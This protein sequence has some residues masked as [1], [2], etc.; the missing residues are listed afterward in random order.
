MV[1]VI[2]NFGGFYPSWVYFNEAR[3]WG[4]KIHLPC[5]NRG[6]YKTC[7]SGDDM[8]VGFIHIN[9]LETH[10][11]KAIHPERQ[12]GGDYLDMDDFI[13]RVQAPLE[14]LIILIR[15]G[16]FRFTGKPKA[17]LLWEAHM[18][19]GKNILLPGS[20]KA[21]KRA[22][23]Q[24]SGQRLGH[25]GGNKKQSLV[26][27]HPG[28]YVARSLQSVTDTPLLVNQSLFYAQPKKF[29]LP[30]LEQSKL[31]EVYDEIE[32]LGWPVTHSYF[33]LL[34][35]SFRGEVMATD[36]M[37]CLGR[38]VRMLGL[39]VTIKYVRTVKK[40]WMH[41]GT[42]I[43]VHGQ[44]FDTVHFPQAVNKY[45]FR[46]EGVYLI[47]GKIVEEFGFP[48]LEVEKMAKMPLQK[49]PRG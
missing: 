8:Y 11:G 25:R 9:N 6:E 26:A 24:E 28:A 5:V 12:R 43:D 45:P 49:D 16:A 38:K 1:G 3:N 15:A 23:E 46:G 36:M 22:G 41:F 29:E 33:D 17:L 39:L 27:D 48:S 20:G 32:L 14:Q 21:K 2:N 37:A 34:E 44:F 31:E 7:I 13:R 42:F 4:A 10:V 47:M 19:M 18:L 35:T 30:A 40:E